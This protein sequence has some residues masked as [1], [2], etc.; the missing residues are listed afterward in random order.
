MSKHYD[1]TQEHKMFER[2][3]K[4]K[5]TGHPNKGLKGRNP[6]SGKTVN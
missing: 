2:A 1:A 5:G 3:D 4:K 6:Y